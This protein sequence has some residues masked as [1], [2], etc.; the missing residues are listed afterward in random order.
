MLV[1]RAP[2]T[3]FTVLLTGLVLFGM[4]DAQATLPRTAQA[5]QRPPNI[6]LILTD[7]LDAAQM[8]NVPRI[9]ELL[10]GQGVSFTNYFDTVSLC[11]PSRTSILRG[12]YTHNHE[13]TGNMP[14]SGG[15]PKAYELGLESSTIATWLHDAGYH[16]AL[17]GKYLNGYPDS[18]QPNYIPPGWTDWYSPAA[19]NP[20][21]EYNYTLNENGT[22]TRHGR[23]PADYL[24]DVLS[25]RADDVVRRAAGEGAPFFLYV[26][27]YA[28]HQPAT[29]APR[30]EDAFPGATA[31][32]VPSFNEADVSDKPAWV[33]ARALLTDQNIAVIDDLYRRRQQSMLAVQDLVV[34]LIDTLQSTG[35]L[36]NTYLFFS[37]DNGFHLGQHRLQPGKQTAYEEDVHVPLLVRG[38]GITAG[39]TVDQLAGEVDLAPTWAELAGV[40]APDFVD[41]RSLVPLLWDGPPPSAWRQVF[42]L[43]HGDTSTIGSGPP[44]RLRRGRTPPVGGQQTNLQANPV[45]SV[46]EP[47]DVDEQEQVARALPAIPAFQ[48]IRTAQ[49]TFVEYVTGEHELY[50]L[51]ADPYELQN[52]YDSADPALRGRLQARLDAERHCAGASCRAAEEQGP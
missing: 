3:L 14:P 5:S 6:I 8:V 16:T 17:L 32:R 9:D 19:G 12:Q 49:Y 41:G 4:P 35:Q 15:F 29:P 27:P 48:A 39:R 36:D 42:L 50:D 40:R 34:S 2:R 11:C 31:P 30:Y 7:D 20:Y 24:V 45:E 18:A 43:E 47:P 13:I 38:P 23:T 52:S 25:A 37:S 28:P 21:S 33:R 26:A 22:L 44:A 10:G 51:Q 1:T 46:L